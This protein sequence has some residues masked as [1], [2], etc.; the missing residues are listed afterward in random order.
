MRTLM[1]F[2]MG[3]AASCGLFAYGRDSRWLLPTAIFAVLLLVAAACLRRKKQRLRIAVT[4]LIGSL[5]GF[6]WFGVCYLGYLQPL[7]MADGERFVLA[8]T[9]SDFGYDTD[10]GTSVDGIVSVEGKRSQIRLYLSEEVRIR[11]G[12]RVEGAFRLAVTMPDEGEDATCFQGKGIFLLAYQRE[13]VTAVQMRPDTL[14]ERA[15]CLRRELTSFSTDES[16][17]SLYPIR[18]HVRTPWDAV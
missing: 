13:K 1:W 18:I 15:A 14:R 10:Y 3:F 11:P 8:V 17:V 16:S 12:D 9:A 2:T 6:G 7:Q 5:L 4:V